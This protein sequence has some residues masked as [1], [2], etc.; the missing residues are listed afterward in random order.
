MDSAIIAVMRLIAVFLAATLTA[1]GCMSTSYQISGAEIQRMAAL[2]PEVR[3]QQV[4][5]VQ[6]LTDNETTG[7]EPVTGQTQIIFM[8]RIYVTDDDR[9]HGG[10]GN[11]GYGYSGGGG[12]G[13]SV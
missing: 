8:P 2:A 13:G 3:G 10:F 11:G 1:T 4:R 5:V 9:H 7:A 6:Q 12:G